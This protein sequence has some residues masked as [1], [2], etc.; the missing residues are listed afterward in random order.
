MA[1]NSS[2]VELYIGKKIQI[3]A[4]LVDVESGVTKPLLMDTYLLSGPLAM[5]TDIAE[6]ISTLLTKNNKSEN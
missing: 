3:T 4:N 1:G 5:Q 2:D 6:K